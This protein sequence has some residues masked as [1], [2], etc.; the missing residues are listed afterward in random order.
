M[1]LQKPGNLLSF[2]RRK[3]VQDD[4]DIL[5]RVAQANHL[6][7]KVHELVAGVSCCRLAVDF[8][9]AHIESGVQ[10]QRAVAII[11]EPVPLGASW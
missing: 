8:T 6:L 11:L 1:F 9:A 7:E 10:G 3:V 2:V 5:I 4:M